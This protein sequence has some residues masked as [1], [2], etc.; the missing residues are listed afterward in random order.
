VSITDQYNCQLVLDDLLINSLSPPVLLIDSMVVD[1]TCYGRQDGL[2]TALVGG[3]TPPYQTSWE[4]DSVLLASNTPV[5]NQLMAG[6]YQ[7]RVVDQM[8]CPTVFHLSVNEPAPLQIDFLSYAPDNQGNNGRALALVEGGTPPYQY[9]WSTGD[10]T[11]VADQLSAGTYTVSVEDINGCQMNDRIQLIPTHNQIT[12]MI[13]R[14]QV[15]P[16]PTRRQS[17]L[18]I[19]SRQPLQ[20]HLRIYSAQGQLIRQTDLGKHRYFQHPISMQEAGKYLLELQDEQGKTLYTNWL[21]AT[22]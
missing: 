21:L 7:F 22:Q 5:I 20:L 4:Q 13:E 14:V 2:L 3:G 16:N 1:V 19:S 15:F 6:T 8:G 18:S 10:S 17:V 9:Q 11:A 12:A